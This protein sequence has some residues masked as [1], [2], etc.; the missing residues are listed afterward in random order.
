VNIIII[1][2]QSCFFLFFIIVPFR[3]K[4]VVIV[5]FLFLV[6]AFFS[7]LNGYPFKI[8]PMQ[9]FN[10]M[11]YI[12]CSCTILIVGRIFV[13]VYRRCVWTAMRCGN[14]PAAWC[15][16]TTC[17]RCRPPKTESPRCPPASWA[18]WRPSGTWC[19]LNFFLLFKR[20]LRRITKP[21]HFTR[22]SGVVK[23]I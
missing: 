6:I 3:E 13:S 21:L 20:P 15:S 16:C 5:N 7:F 11:L 8:L 19:V 17:T 9:F 14:C 22:P 10:K 18:T 4:A 2:R 1:K 12:S 23:K